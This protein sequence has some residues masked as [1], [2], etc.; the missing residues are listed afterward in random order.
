MARDA[1][2]PDDVFQEPERH[3]SRNRDAHL[4]KAHSRR[5]PPCTCLNFRRLRRKSQPLIHDS[6][7][8]A[9]IDATADADEC[10]PLQF[11]IAEKLMS[12]LQPIKEMFLATLADPESKEVRH[13]FCLGRL[14]EC[15]QRALLSAHNL[16]LFRSYTAECF[17]N[18]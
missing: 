1:A 17:S 2:L 13:S 11:V 3:P 16:Y 14:C 12:H 9:V 8:H 7:S 18:K 10:P 6:W 4:L 5:S 15:M